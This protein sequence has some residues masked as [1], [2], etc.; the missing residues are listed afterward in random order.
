MD[1]F[2]RSETPKSGDEEVL[3][4]NDVTPTEKVLSRIDTETPMEMP[5]MPVPEPLRVQKKFKKKAGLVIG[6]TTLVFT[7][8]GG[9]VWFML[10]N[11]PAQNNPAGDD[12]AVRPS[13]NKNDDG[14]KIG[15]DP[16]PEDE[17]I[18]LSVD[19]ALVRRLYAQFN[20]RYYAQDI[21]VR[22]VEGANDDT[23]I[24]FAIASQTATTVC[25]E[26]YGDLYGN[27]E[28]DPNVFGEPWP[29]LGENCVSG[30]SV[31]DTIRTTFGTELKLQ[32]KQ[33]A[34]L[35]CSVFIY[36]EKNNEFIDM[37]TGCSGPLSSLIRGLYAAEKSGNSL[38]LFETVTYRAPLAYIDGSIAGDNPTPGIE[39][40]LV[41]DDG[42]AS[43]EC[44][45]KDVEIN[46]NNIVQYKNQLSKFK[47]TFVWNGENYVFERLEQI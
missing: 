35:H 6:A 41:E 27:G 8:V 32:N 12:I 1:D 29:V 14:E 30:N 26:K 44:I 34:R 25:K 42:S 24:A 23:K 28:Y 18:E 38:F 45:L 11:T 47:W 22:L 13:D 5:Q 31:L 40:C 33:V 46:N 4:L 39:Y 7:L 9:A 15:D 17:A 10:A 21:W 19:D 20:V 37:S 36:D 43:K 3:Q 2:E 16:A